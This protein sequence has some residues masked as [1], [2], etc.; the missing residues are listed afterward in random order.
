[1]KTCPVCD[2]AGLLTRDVP[3][4]GNM[5]M[6]LSIQDVCYACGGTGEVTQDAWDTWQIH[7]TMFPGETDAPL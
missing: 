7:G 6:D 4:H 3:E 5:S 2:G 1:M